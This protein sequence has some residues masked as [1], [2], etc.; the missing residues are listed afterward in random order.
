MNIFDR[1][2]NS[3]GLDNFDKRHK[4]GLSL[5]IVAMISITVLWVIELRRNIVE[6]LYAGLKTNQTNDTLSNNANDEELKAKDT[7]SDGLNDF[8]ELNLYKTSPYLADSD[9]DTFSDKSEIDS[10]NDPNCPK[11]KNCF[12]SSDQTNQ[13]NDSLSSGEILNNTL[14]AP[15]SVASPSVSG[16]LTAEQ[17]KAIQDTLGDKINDAP[18]IRTLLSQLGMDK[19]TLDALSDQQIIETLNA[20]LK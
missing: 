17:K 6:P 9:S 14:Q 19:A 5:L 8:D 13:G 3:L 12:L 16:G 15:S 11:G 1:I 7:D 10:G 4:V 18:T 2:A 20:L